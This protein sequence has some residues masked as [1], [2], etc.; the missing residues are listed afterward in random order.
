[1]ELRVIR[2][3]DN[4]PEEASSFEEAFGEFSEARGRGRER[5]RKRRSERKKNRQ[6]QRM[7]RIKNRAERRKEKRKM[8]AEALEDRLAKRRRR[9]EERVSRKAMGETEEEPMMEEETTEEEAPEESEEETEEPEEEVEETEEEE[10]PEEEE[11]TSGFNASKDNFDEYFNYSG[12]DF[13]NM[14]SIVSDGSVLNIMEF[15]K[16]AEDYYSGADGTPVKINSK[17]KDITNKIEWNKEIIARLTKKLRTSR[18]GREE[19]AKTK[20]NLKDR[21]NALAL[22]QEQLRQYSKYATA[23]SGSTLANREIAKS[24]SVARLNRFKAI[25]SN[26]IGMTPEAALARSINISKNRLNTSETPVDSSLRADISQGRIVVPEE[27]LGESCFNGDGVTQYDVTFSNAVG[28][29]KKKKR[30]RIIAI[31]GGVVLASVIIYLV[32][33]R[34]K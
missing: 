33:R 15:Q 2:L 3:G 26:K 29:D 21:Q 30:N 16:G 19:A 28:D 22:L 18:M 4:S 17:L 13:Y 1:M 23:K 20:A 7:T 8:R 5:R 6:E 10:A 24:S 31:V 32:A 34:K 12:D 11:E 14:D 25:G 27:K 9:K